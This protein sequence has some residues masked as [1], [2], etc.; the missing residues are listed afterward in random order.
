MAVWASAIWA[1]NWPK[2]LTSGL[3]LK[4]YSES[5]IF[6]AAF[7]RFD[8]IAWYAAFASSLIRFWAGRA[9][10]AMP[11][12]GKDSVQFV[13]CDL[14]VGGFEIIRWLQFASETECV[15]GDLTGRPIRDCCRRPYSGPVRRLRWRQTRG[16]R[17]SN[18]QAD[19]TPCSPR[20]IENTA[21]PLLVRT[22][23]TGR[24]CEP[25]GHSSS[26]HHHLGDDRFRRD[27]EDD[28]KCSGSVLLRFPVR[29][30]R[31]PVD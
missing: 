24:D 26:W 28:E 25:V 1:I 10:T 21:A 20:P 31:I 5:G 14:R 6:S 9:A 13:S 2:V 17:A 18:I 15:T 12:R 30:M 19:C 23:K 8:L 29:G 3:G 16:L 27:A 4:L 22:G 11:R 7:R